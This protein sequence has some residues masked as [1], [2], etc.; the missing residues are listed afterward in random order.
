MTCREAL[1]F[2]SDYIAG[3][4]PSDTHQTFQDHLH[5][6]PNCKVLVDQIRA[7]IVLAERSGREPES[8]PLSDELVAAIMKT[9]K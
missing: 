3:E 4:L 7:T 6:C 1:D 2:L 5:R 8:L 9:L